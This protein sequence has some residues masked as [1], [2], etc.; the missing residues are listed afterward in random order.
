MIVEY[1]GYLGKVEFDDE[2]ELFHGQVMH[3]RDVVTFQA[4]TAK[5]LKKA[6]RESVQT[7][8]QF[9]KERG[10]EP[11][12]PFSGK[13]VLRVAPELH[14]RLAAQAAREEKSLNEWIEENLEKI[15]A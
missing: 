14:K 4:K 7:Y 13:F 15:A 6:M 11:Q 2:A 10:A 9:C 3:L 5:E 12:K 8:M 1:K